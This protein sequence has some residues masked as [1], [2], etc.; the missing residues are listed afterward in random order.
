[1]FDE[2]IQQNKVTKM[3]Y[4]HRRLVQYEYSWIRDDRSGDCHALALTT[5]EQ[6]PSR[7]N[8][9]I[10][11]CVEAHHKIERIRS[12]G[13]LDDLFFGSVGLTHEDVIADCTLKQYRHL[14]HITDILAKPLGIEITNILAIESDRSAVG[15]VKL[16][17][18]LES[19]RF[20]TSA[21]AYKGNRLLRLDV[22][23]ETRPITI[24]RGSVDQVIGPRGIRKRYVLERNSAV[25]ARWLVAA[26]IER[27][28]LVIRLVDDLEDALRGG[29]SI[30]LRV[31]IYGHLSNA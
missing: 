25:D 16:E 8:V 5:A 27:I 19:G 17:E 22:K 7:S 3:H 18:Q 30:L 4:T 1:M 11:P 12:L 21:L 31:E 14:A 26:R 2:K 24:R 28:H 15:L 9:C 20:T 23:T 13:R 6:H 29:E 10:K